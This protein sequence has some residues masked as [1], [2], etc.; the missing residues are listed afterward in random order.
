MIE[1]MRRKRLRQNQTGPTHAPTTTTSS[2][3]P[4]I[5]LCTGK[6]HS[7]S[8]DLGVRTHA[9]AHTLTLVRCSLVK[10]HKKAAKGP[11]TTTTAAATKL[12]VNLT[13]WETGRESDDDD[14]DSA[15]RA[16]QNTA[17]SRA[18]RSTSDFA[19]AIR[20]RRRRRQ[21]RRRFCRISWER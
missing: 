8:P 10:R 11:M 6:V 7:E 15:I 12:K 21:R 18:I 20:R 17:L 5:K 16:T 14:D 4:L 1:G 3:R 13:E 19:L 9:N 2:D